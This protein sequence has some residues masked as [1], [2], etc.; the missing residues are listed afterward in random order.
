MC[1]RVV[2]QSRECGC[3]SEHRGHGSQRQP[4]CRPPQ[5][6]WPIGRSEGPRKSSAGPQPRSAPTARGC[7]RSRLPPRRPECHLARPNDPRGAVAGR[8]PSTIPSGS[9]ISVPC[10]QRPGAGPRSL[11][12][13]ARRGAPPTATQERTQ[14]VRTKYRRSVR[15]ESRSLRRHLRGGDPKSCPTCKRFSRASGKP[16]ATMAWRRS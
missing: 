10:R 3:H 7:P 13:A 14:A 16:A 1:T 9:V 2:L 6:G 8:Q 12:S 11:L 4:D 5:P 15:T